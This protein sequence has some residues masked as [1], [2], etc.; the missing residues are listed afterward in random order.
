M[1][2]RPQF[3]TVSIRKIKRA[4][5]NKKNRINIERIRVLPMKLRVW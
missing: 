1:A 3:S 2:G 5:K 4:Q